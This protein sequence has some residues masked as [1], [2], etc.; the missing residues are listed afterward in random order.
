MRNARNISPSSQAGKPVY[1]VEYSG[2][3]SKFCAQ[4]NA[5]QFY[6]MKKKSSLNAYRE[7]CR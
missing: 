6:A 7:T 3:P 4:T 1:D 5:L 2:A